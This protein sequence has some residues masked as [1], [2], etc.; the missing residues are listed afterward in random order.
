MLVEVYDEQALCPT[1]C[2]EWS[3]KFKS[4]EFDLKNKES[5][6]PSKMSNDDKLQA[7]FDKDDGQMQ[8]TPQNNWMMTS[9]PLQNVST[10]WKRF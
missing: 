2:N 3:N 5:G 1:Q 4:G 10:P 7:L 6:K 9:H 8:E